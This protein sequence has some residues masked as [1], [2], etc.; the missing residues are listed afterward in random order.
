[1]AAGYFACLLGAIRWWKYAD[2][3]R[4]HRL[5]FWSTA[6]TAASAFFLS[7]LW[8][9]PQPVGALLAGMIAFATQLASPWL[10]PSQRRALAEQEG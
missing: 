2:Y 1:V 10:P 3:T 6:I 7:F 8:W 9:F 5:G 4:T